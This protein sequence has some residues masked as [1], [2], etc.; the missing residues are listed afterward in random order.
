[1]GLKRNLAP[2]ALDQ[3]GISYRHG[4]GDH[5]S[6]RVVI[7]NDSKMIFRARKCRKDDSAMDKRAMAIDTNKKDR[8]V[9]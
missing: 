6:N 5:G 4:T 7:P 2:K 3:M 1:M 8:V 9:L